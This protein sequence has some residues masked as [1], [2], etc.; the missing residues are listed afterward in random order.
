MQTVIADIGLIPNG[1]QSLIQV[2]EAKGNAVARTYII[3]ERA[4]IDRVSH[5][6]I[7]FSTVRLQ[8]RRSPAYLH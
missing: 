6:H 5:Q 3:P 8:D 7:L 1:K 2:P 4:G